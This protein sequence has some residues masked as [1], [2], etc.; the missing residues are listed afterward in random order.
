VPSPARLVISD[1]SVKLSSDDRT[2]ST[3]LSNRGGRSLTFDLDPDDGWLSVDPNDGH[4]DPGESTTVTVS[5]S[6]G[7]PPRTDDDSSIDVDWTNGSDS[8]SVRFKAEKRDDDSE[9]PSPSPSPQ[10]GPSGPPPFVS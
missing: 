5:V 8:I 9:Q 2:T 6:R 7:D 3:T 10:D 4:L 1:H